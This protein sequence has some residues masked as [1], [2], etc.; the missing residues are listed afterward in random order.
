MLPSHCFWPFTL[1]RMEEAGL[2]KKMSDFLL[3]VSPSSQASPQADIEVGQ[4]CSRYPAFDI[5]NLT[6]NPRL[7]LL[8][9]CSCTNC[10][11]VHHGVGLSHISFLGVPAADIIT[12]S[13]SPRFSLPPS[14][15]PSGILKIFFPVKWKVKWLLTCSQQVRDKF[16]MTGGP[17]LNLHPPKGSITL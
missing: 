1:V 13:L 14:S 16:F 4:R 12:P 7:P 6:C 9:G 10:S 11:Q 17:F 15:P 2:V 3:T 8:P 5:C